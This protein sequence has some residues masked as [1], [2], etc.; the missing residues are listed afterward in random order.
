MKMGKQNIAKYYIFI[1]FCTGL[2]LTNSILHTI[3]FSMYIWLY[4]YENNYIIS[5]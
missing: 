4:F 1:L 3:L 5:I 2:H